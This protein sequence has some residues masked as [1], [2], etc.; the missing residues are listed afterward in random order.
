MAEES[1]LPLGPLSV[2]DDDDALEFARRNGV[3]P[4]PPELEEELGVPSV[5]PT[6]NWMEWISGSGSDG[7]TVAL[8]FSTIPVDKLVD[9]RRTDGQARALLRVLTLPIRAAWREAEFVAPDYLE[10]GQKADDEVEFANR[11]FALPPSHGGMEVSFGHVLRQILLA[12]LEGFSAFEEVRYVPDKGPLK[13]KVVL[14]KL[15]H[16]SSD[17][18]RFRVDDNGNFDGMYQIARRPNGD[19]VH[20][21]LPKEKCWYY[22]VQEEENAFYGVSYFESA[23]WHHTVKKRLYYISQV[24]AQFGAVPGRVGQLPPSVKPSE[25][26][27]F[28]KALADFS[29]NTAMTVPHGY[30]VNPFNGS[31]GFDF[32]KL[33]DHHNLAMAK[34]VLATFMEKESRQVLID[35]ANRDE[36]SD[37]LVMAIESLMDE[38]AERIT[39]HLMPK[40]ID[41]NFTNGAYPVFK[42]PP[43]SDSGRDVIK[44]LLTT[45]ATAQSSMLTPEMIR[46]M[47]K[48][49]VLRLGLDV[50]YDE[51]DKRE[52]E[53]KKQAE[54]QMA[55]QMGQQGGEVTEGEEGGPTG[56]DTNVPPEYQSD[57][58]AGGYQSFSA[59]GVTISMDAV[60]EEMRRMDERAD[61]A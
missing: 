17:T 50:D 55:A 34:S 57:D 20:V 42:F 7:G 41:W 9:M 44:D 47:E 6:S 36:A 24:A 35:N 49:M 25:L 33:L 40:Y 28:K 48:K 14:K 39:H 32:V 59:T 8:N 22:A 3:T 58:G 4:K 38:I 10:D 31:T 26:R 2:S 51:V 13:G 11:M 18:I 60:L 19:P 29:F 21:Y 52:A 1:Q 16:R 27:A 56:P 30:A 53:E 37:L 5:L 54:E 23:Y 15:A 43:L 46:E 12:I 45:I 61:D